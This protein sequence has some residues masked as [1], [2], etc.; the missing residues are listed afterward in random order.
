MRAFR[1]AAE[2]GCDLIE[3]DV[4]LS[5]DGLPVVIHDDALDRTT[6]GRGRVASHTWEELRALDAGMGE[7]IPSLEEVIDW[8]RSGSF[9]LSIEIK[10]PTP[11]YGDPR[12]AGIEERVV[13]LVR[14]A[15]L[16]ERCLIHSFDHPTI[17]RVREIWPAATTAISYGGGT[18][19]DP[20]ALGRS[21]AASGIHPWWAWVSPD[22]A[23]LAHEAGMHV[24]AW[25]M[26]QPPLRGEVEALVHAGV[27]SLDANDPRRLRA[28]LDDISAATP[29]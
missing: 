19:T 11:A 9:W 28:I 21:A 12:Y 7:R 8:A 26:T 27:D 29:T 25:G 6:S 10:Q 2:V 20:L 24:H 15:R 14:A 4:H 23:R 16:D 22:V 13:D 5:R 17:R 3:L 18:L 1:R